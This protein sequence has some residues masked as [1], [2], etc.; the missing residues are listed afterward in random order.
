MRTSLVRSLSW[1]VFLGVFPAG[2]YT[3]KEW[4]DSQEAKR[5]EYD[6][7]C[8]EFLVDPYKVGCPFAFQCAR[9]KGNLPTQSLEKSA[10]MRCLWPAQP[11][12]VHVR[13]KGCGG[14]MG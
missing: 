10:A 13:G 5:K 3:T 7:H 12:S 9:Q 11:G 1:R 4:L 2:A 14:T 6:R 8:E